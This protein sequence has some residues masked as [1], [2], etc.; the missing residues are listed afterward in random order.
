[1]LPLQLEPV[2]QI[3]LY[4]LRG[5]TF[6]P[7]PHVNSPKPKEPVGPVKPVGPVAILQIYLYYMLK[8]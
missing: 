3:A 4:E 1:M 6:T 8:A 7:V 2:V 5:E